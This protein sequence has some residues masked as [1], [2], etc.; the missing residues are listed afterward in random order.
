MACCN[1]RLY[2]FCRCRDDDRIRRL[3]ARTVIVISKS[4]ERSVWFRVPYH[5][6]D[7]SFWDRRHS[8]PR[9]RNE[10]AK[11]FLSSC[12]PHRFHICDHRRGTWISWKPGFYYLNDNLC[13][14]RVLNRKKSTGLVRARVGIWDSH[15]DRR[16]SVLKHR[17]SDRIS[18]GDG[19]TTA[20]CEL[21]RVITSG[22]I[23]QHRHLIEYFHQQK[24]ECCCKKTN[25]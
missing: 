9:A 6:I 19:D 16:A 20:F 8:R 10:Q 13:H 23:G 7:D 17:G 14:K 25:G 11:I 2:R 3:Q 21:R 22:I 1:N 4:L 15:T 24:E 12:G 18:P 5:S